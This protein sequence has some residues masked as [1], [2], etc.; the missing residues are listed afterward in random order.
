[1]TVKVYRLR[2]KA[3]IVQCIYG[4]SFKHTP[5][6]NADAARVARKHAKDN[7]G[8]EVVVDSDQTTTYKA[9]EVSR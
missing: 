4:C 6:D 8:H 9:S 7:P 3:Y 1:M 5:N 2:V